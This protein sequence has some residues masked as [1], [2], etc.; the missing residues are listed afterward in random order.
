MP[1][2]KRDKKVSLTKTTKKGLE[3]KQKII[4][5]LIE[6]CE[7]YDNVFLLNYENMRNNKLKEIRTQW[8]GSRFF[9]GKN[10][11]MK[12]GLGK[13]EIDEKFVQT[14]EGQCGLLFTN[15][16]KKVVV[17]WFETYVMD[18]F[19]RSGFKAEETIVLYE[20]KLRL[21]WYWYF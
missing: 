11:V 2:S 7:K 21:G 12:L 19:A 8:N 6:C 20:G 5:D 15:E 10:N 4:E 1:K 14:L 3:G 18:E 13:A 17:D 9:F 16:S